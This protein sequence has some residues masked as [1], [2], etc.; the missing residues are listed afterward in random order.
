M[1]DELKT[2]SLRTMERTRQQIDDAKRAKDLYDTL[3]NPKP[4]GDEPA[5]ESG[6]NGGATQGNSEEQG[7]APEANRELES[8][9]DE[10]DR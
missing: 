8:L 9:I 5:R 3:N 1:P 10:A 7:Y 2:E 4:R 6:A